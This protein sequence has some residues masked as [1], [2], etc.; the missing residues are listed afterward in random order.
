M[1]FF[2][3]DFC[4]TGDRRGIERFSVEEMSN[5]LNVKVGELESSLNAIVCVKKKKKC[6]QNIMKIPSSVRLFNELE[7][8]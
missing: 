3:F 4:C 5:N 7:A 8:P 1:T 6:G 2:F